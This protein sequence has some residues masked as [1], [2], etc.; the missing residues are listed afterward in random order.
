VGSL[1][2]V[3]IWNYLFV[4]PYGIVG[5]ATSNLAGFVVRIILIYV[6][7]QRFFRIPFE[8]GRLAFAFAVAC[9]MYAGSQ[10]LTLSS[11][12]GTLGVRL[13][14]AALFPC[15]LLLCGFFRHGERVFA[16]QV[17]RKICR[18]PESPPCKS[19]L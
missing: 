9:L 8:V 3:L 6:V 5:A 13:A 10:Q 12:Y 4:P 11:P 14:V 18:V 1:A 17:L 7:S 19:L 2:V 16:A 15:V